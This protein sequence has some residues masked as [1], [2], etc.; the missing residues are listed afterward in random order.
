MPSVIAAESVTKEEQPSEAS[1]ADET[2]LDSLSPLS[3]QPQSPKAAL[4]AS[5]FD[6]GY[7]SSAVSI[8]NAANESF[9][10]L[11]DVASSDVSVMSSVS[12]A[13][14]GLVSKGKFSPIGQIAEGL[15]EEARLIVDRIQAELGVSK[16]EQEE[17]ADESELN[18][19]GVD[20][21]QADVSVLESVCEVLR[22]EVK[23]EVG[24]IIVIF[25]Y[26]EF[27]P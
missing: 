5:I 25:I 2:A 20:E 11:E 18:R 19:S 21:S 9:S 4:T 12:F 14:S 1:E 7:G 22:E 13:E 24:F 3:P 10:S 17:V 15:E 23:E 8:K 16:A 26:L 6:D 27:A